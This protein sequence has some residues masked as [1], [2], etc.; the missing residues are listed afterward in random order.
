M[1]ARTTSKAAA[2]V[3]ALAWLGG[4]ATSA[5]AEDAPIDEAVTIEAPADDSSVDPTI[6]LYSSEDTPA[7]QPVDEATE[8]ELADDSGLAEN[9]VP[10]ENQR[11]VDAPMMATTTAAGTEDSDSSNSALPIAAGAIALAAAGAIVAKRR[12]GSKAE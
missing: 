3:L 11:S 8:E 12:S 2:D 9:G 4:S 1:K 7:E 6:E 10:A 5:F